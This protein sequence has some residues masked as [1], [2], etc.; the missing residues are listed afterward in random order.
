VILLAEEWLNYIMVSIR[1]GFWI[2]IYIV[3]LCFSLV[4]VVDEH[5]TLAS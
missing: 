2:E 5:G 4:R 1:N 3:R